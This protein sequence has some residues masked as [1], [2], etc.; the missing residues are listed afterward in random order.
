LGGA[1][2]H[3]AHPFDLPGV[4]TGEDLVNFFYNVGN[5]VANTPENAS[6]KIDGVNV[7]FKLIDGPHGK[8]FAIDRGSL[9]PIDIEGVTIDRLQDRFPSKENEETGE[10]HTHGMV[11]AG[12]ALLTILNSS[13]KEITPELKKLGM[14]DDP[15][16]FL[17]TEFVL[18]KTNVTEYDKNFLALH[19]LNQFFEKDSKRTGTF[20][21]GI[22]RPEGVSAPSAEVDYDRGTLNLLADKLKAHAK[23][24]DFEVYTSVP[25]SNETNIS[26]EKTLDS[27]FTIQM[28]PDSEETHP[29]SAWLSGVVNPG[30]ERVTIRYADG[31]TKEIGAL[32]KEVYI[33]ALNE[34]PFVELF[35]N[36]EDLKTAISGAVFYHATRVL[37]NDVL[38]ALGSE[39]GPAS[40]HEGVVLR[41]VPGAEN[42]PVKITGEFILGGMT[43]GF[44]ENAQKTLKEQKNSID[45]IIAIYPGRFQPMGRHHSEVF[46]KIENEFGEENTFLATADVTNIAEKDGIPTSPFDFQEKQMIAVGHG[47]PYNRVVMTKNPY[48]AEEVLNKFDPE[49]TAVVFF[50]GSK[51]MDE[52]PRFSSL[53]GYTKSGN[54][55]YFRKFDKKEELEGFDKHGYIAT[56]PHVPIPVHMG[57]EAEP[58]EMSGTVLRQ[59]LKNADEATF[60]E[61]MGYFDPEV[62]QIIKNKLTVRVEENQFNLGIFRG[63]MEEVYEELQEEDEELEEIS[64]AA[65]VTGYSLPLGT[66]PPRKKKRKKKERADEEIVNEFYDYLVHKMRSRK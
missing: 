60:K 11:P 64:T 49:T 22:P 30:G 59:V 63:L 4:D 19:S 66:T 12:Q 35:P 40:S 18:G 21:P 3:M 13:L 51:D 62:F 28:T 23:E 39:L 25:V 8:E 52:D 42:A 2:G 36:R 14:Y 43:S 31:S 24:N 32:S 33:N 5:H 45:R 6:L 57:D 26:Y 37:G 50:V 9:K 29:L 41:N 54:P 56:A 1:A 58:L 65:A 48:Q 16:K 55:R 10:L 20:R 15:T 7:S 34:V 17:N 47:I 44:K 61:I 38:K 46:K 27:P 53:D